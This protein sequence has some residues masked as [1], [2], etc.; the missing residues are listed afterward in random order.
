MNHKPSRG[1][2]LVEL[3]VVIAII[4]I[5]VALLLPAVQAAR[6]AAR[7]MQC[8]NNLKQFGLALHNYHSAHGRFPPGTISKDEGG[9]GIFRKPEW[10]YLIVHLLPFLEQQG[11]LDLLDV[12]PPLTSPSRYNA[13]NV[14]PQGIQTASVSTFQCPSDGYGD[15]RL[16]MDA[17][18]GYTNTAK[19][20]RSN[21]LGIFS[22]ANMQDVA[23]RSGES[24]LYTP[25]SYSSQFIRAYGARG[26]RA[27]F[28]INLST[29]IRDITD[30]TS[31]TLM[32]VEHLTDNAFR[33]W[34]WT[35]QASASVIFAWVTPNSS[36]PDHLSGCDLPGVNQP[37]MNLPCVEESHLYPRTATAR[38]RHPG[39]VDVVL[40][41]GSAHFISDT[42][43]V[44][45]WRAL[46]TIQAGE[47]NQ[48]P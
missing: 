39:G 17:L 12:N 27:L 18:L 28:D 9:E 32:M 2:T 37:E 15:K 34:F 22:G 36:S 1:F 25:G 45:L 42:V 29:K 41:D 38:S 14:W 7:R 20:F 24:G 19:L 16:N 30:G 26:E 3:L 13:A 21:Y 46:G 43:D 33:G 4:A 44:N 8:N 48:Q 11:M 47:V 40:A 23:F 5:L 35:S 10:P 31:Y 6:E